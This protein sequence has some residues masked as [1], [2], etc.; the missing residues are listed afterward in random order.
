MSRQ[1]T[2]LR[3][4]SSDAGRNRSFQLSRIYA[5][6]WNA[7]KAMSSDA[8]LDLDA[9]KTAAMNPFRLEDER[10]RWAEGFADAALARD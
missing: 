7:A 6:G 5:K 10:R 3:K 2:A 4:T 8:L 1:Q 9:A